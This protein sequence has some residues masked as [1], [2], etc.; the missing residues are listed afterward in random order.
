MGSLLA[1]LSSV[2]PSAKP[3][4]CLQSKLD[5]RW[6]LAR[7]YL[8]AMVANKGKSF[9]TARRIVRWQIDSLSGLRV[10]DR[11]RIIVLFVL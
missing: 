4:K 6:A 8:A 5:Y 1:D 7:L 11:D 2:H 10:C 9:S 3:T